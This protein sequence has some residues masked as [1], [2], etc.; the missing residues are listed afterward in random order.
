MDSILEQTHTKNKERYANCWIRPNKAQVMWKPQISTHLLHYPQNLNHCA[1]DQNN[2]QKHDGKSKK[3]QILLQISDD[4][5]HLNKLVS[6]C[7]L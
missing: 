1:L 2:L 3:N 6:S 5:I 4:N 7:M